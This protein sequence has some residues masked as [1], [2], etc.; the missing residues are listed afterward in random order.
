MAPRLTAGSKDMFFF[1]V[2]NM[3]ELDER[4]AFPFYMLLA[5]ALIEQFALLIP[6]RT[7]RYQRLRERGS[8][9]WIA[10]S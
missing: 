5:L 7:V 3:K 9:I 2:E 6:V 1:R 10:G 8:G 4:E